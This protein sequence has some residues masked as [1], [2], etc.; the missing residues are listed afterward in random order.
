[1]YQKF[2]FFSSFQVQ[3]VFV[4]PKVF[5]NRIE[6]NYFFQRINFIFPKELRQSTYSM[7][8][9]KKKRNLGLDYFLNVR[10]TIYNIFGILN[11]NSVITFFNNVKHRHSIPKI[12]R[13]KF[14]QFFP[15]RNNYRTSS[16][17]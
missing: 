6:I 11:R 12:K 1:F 15:V 8:V 13:Q 4:I 2:G 3:I 7:T 14:V 16:I 9:R 10:Y 5:F 17:N